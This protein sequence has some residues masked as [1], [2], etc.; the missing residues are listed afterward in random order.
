MYSTLVKKEKFQNFTQNVWKVLAT[1]AL[2]QPSVPFTL[3][4]L[5]SN[6]VVIVREE[7]SLFTQHN[8]ID[9]NKGEITEKPQTYSICMF[10][11]Q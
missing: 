1:K 6:Q 11:I 5:V 3:N 9:S 10:E 2:H 4:F 7:Y 8:H